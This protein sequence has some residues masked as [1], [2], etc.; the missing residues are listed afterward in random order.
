MDVNVYDFD[1]TI[2]KNDTTREFYLYLIKKQPQILLYLPKQIF[3]FILFE[4]KIIEKTKFKEKF[5]TFLK[6]VKD[7][8]KEI[9][10][11]W[12]KN[13]KNINPWYYEIKKDT[14]IVISASPKFLLEHICK[15]LGVSYLIASKVDKNTGKYDGPNCF[16]EE[17]VKRFYKEKS[18]VTINEFYSDS[19][20]D[21]PLAKIAKNSYFVVGEDLYNWWSYKTTKN[22]SKIYTR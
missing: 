13:I 18:D 3:Y 2:S 9:G 4:L 8:D 5:F 11:F 22:T 15:E 16:G 20:T 10:L 1:K 19:F 21:E 6:I 7:I 17:K 12:K 14:D